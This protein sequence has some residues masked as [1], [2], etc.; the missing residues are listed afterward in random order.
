MTRRTFSTATEGGKQTQDYV[1][2][3]GA[4][5][6][7]T[8]VLQTFFFTTRIMKFVGDTRKEIEA[9]QQNFLVCRH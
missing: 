9:T 1:T 8:N 4:E 6:L 3:E 2:A 5:A 7:V